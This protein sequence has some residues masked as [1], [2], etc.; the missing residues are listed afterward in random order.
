MACNAPF[1]SVALLRGAG[2]KFVSQFQAATTEHTCTT[3]PATACDNLAY[4][5]NLMAQLWYDPQG[6]LYEVIDYVNNVS[7]GSTYFVHDGNALV[8]EYNSQGAMLRRYVHGSNVEA[9]DPLIWYEGPTTNSSARRYVHSDPRGSI[10]AVANFQGYSLATN[11][12]DGS[13]AE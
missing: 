4:T 7:Q 11:S 9:D 6:R 12:Y 10:V 8:A 13:A 3:N 5:G 1:F 2:L